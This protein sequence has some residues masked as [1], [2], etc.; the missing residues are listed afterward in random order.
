MAE[1]KEKINQIIKKYNAKGG[2]RIKIP[3]KWK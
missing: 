1:Y 3:A 2:K